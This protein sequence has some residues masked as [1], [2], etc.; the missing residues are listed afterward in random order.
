MGPGTYTLG[1]AI[2]WAGIF[3]A[4]ALVLQGTPYFAQLLPI[5]AGGAVW[6]VVLVPG[7][8]ARRAARGTAADLAASDVAARRAGR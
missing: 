3:L 6:F 2:V 4:S 8:M 1:A 7:A 5:L